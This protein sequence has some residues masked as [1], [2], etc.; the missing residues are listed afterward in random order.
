MYIS[1]HIYIYIYIYVYIYIYFLWIRYMIAR[2]KFGFSLKECLFG[3]VKLADLDKY[4][5]SGCDIGFDLGSELESC[6]RSN[7]RSRKY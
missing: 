5:Y 6:N 1:M 3:C 2:I 4:L 7:T